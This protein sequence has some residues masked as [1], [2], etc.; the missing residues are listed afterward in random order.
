MVQFFWRFP[1]WL[2]FSTVGEIFVFFAY[3][4]AVNLIESAAVL[5][6][7]S[8][9]IFILPREWG[10]EQFVAKATLFVLVM[11]GY[12]IYLNNIFSATS[13]FDLSRRQWLFWLGVEGLILVLPLTRVPAFCRLVE[14]MA[15]RF[16]VFLYVVTPV[17]VIS[18]LF[19][20]VRNLF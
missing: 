5:I 8:A 17:S 6:L 7:V 3:T 4:A 19:V 9:L 18:L 20:L 16:V 11:L 12:L 15:D 2:Y 10:Y 14:A 1:S 13:L